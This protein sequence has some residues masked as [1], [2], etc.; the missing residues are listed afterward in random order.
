MTSRNRNPLIIVQARMASTR[1]PGKMM[2]RIAG[3]ELMNWVVDSAKAINSAQSI[4]VATT[5]NEEDSL[6]EEHAIKLGLNCFRGSSEDVLDRFYNCALK[7]E[8][9]PII[10]LCG[11]SP[12]LSAEYMDDLLKHHMERGSDLTHAA[13]GAPLGTAGEIISFTALKKAHES[14]KSNYQREHVTPFIHEEK[15]QFKITTVDAPDWLTGDYRL[16]IDERADFEMFEMLLQELIANGIKCD[17]KNAIA[18]LSK[19]PDIAKINEKVIQR[20]WRQKASQ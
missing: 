20:N 3:K 16:T 15:A 9:D 5:T 14:A 4:V 10:R 1:L 8:A 17:L 6:L 12:L 7:Y 2:M 11:D 19:R 18:V 13:K